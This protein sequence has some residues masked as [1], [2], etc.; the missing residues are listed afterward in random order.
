MPS[1]L[2]AC[3]SECPV[4]MRKAPECCCVDVTWGA[5]DLSYAD[6]YVRFLS[7]TPRLQHALC[8]V[9]CMPGFAE[10]VAERWFGGEGSTPPAS[11]NVVY[12]GTSKS[13][14]Q[15]YLPRWCGPRQPSPAPIMPHGSISKPSGAFEQ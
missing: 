2:F 5:Q 11:S 7:P 10:W 9:F 13:L 15:I 12:A 8:R 6:N 4:Q 3:F 1:C 14:A